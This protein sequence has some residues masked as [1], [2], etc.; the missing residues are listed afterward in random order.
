MTRKRQSR[1]A[2]QEKRQVVNTTK[3]P[4][5]SLSKKAL[6]CKRVIV[7]IFLCLAGVSFLTHPLWKTSPSAVPNDV[8]VEEPAAPAEEMHSSATAIMRQDLPPQAQPVPAKMTKVAASA[9]SP[10][11]PS[12]PAASAPAPLAAVSPAPVSTPGTSLGQSSNRGK[13]SSSQ[14]AIANALSETQSDTGAKNDAAPERGAN[15]VP[16]PAMAALPPPPAQ[17]NRDNLGWRLMAQLALRDTNCLQA[18]DSQ[19]TQGKIPGNGWFGIAETLA[20]ESLK[21]GLLTALPADD[22][23]GGSKE[24]SMQREVLIQL[25]LSDI[26]ND[27]PRQFLLSALEKLRGQTTLQTSAFSPASAAPQGLAPTLLPAGGPGTTPSTNSDP[28]WAFIA[29]LALRDDD[30]LIVLLRQ[31]DLKTIPSAGWIGI[32]ST[33]PTQSLKEGLLESAKDLFSNPEEVSRRLELIESLMVVS[34][35]AGVSEL[36]T[37]AQSQLR[38]PDLIVPR[39]SAS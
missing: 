34:P 28:S 38:R 24:L 15:F 18:L 39:N 29:Q 5:K 21:Q 10:V 1:F 13:Q 31:A 35:N 22:L 23:R 9:Q 17:T 19:A 30:A 3:P 2:A 12:S 8:A 16:P 26:P 36:L 25:L 11:V 33:L 14:Q 4:R 27:S 20:T 6:T 32:A 37:K 7:L